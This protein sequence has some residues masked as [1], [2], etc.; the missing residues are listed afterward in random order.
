MDTIDRRTRFDQDVVEVDPASFFTGRLS[1]LIERHGHLA[2]AGFDELRARPLTVEVDGFRRTL[3]GERGT[4]TVVEGGV[5][6]AAV[7][8][9]AQ[10][11]F[12]DWAQQLR[13]FSAMTSVGELRRSSGS[14]RQ[15]AVWDALWI[16][17]LE[18]WPVVDHD[19]SFVDRLGSPL[20]LAR[21]FTPEDD[22]D[23]VAHFL[24]EAGFLHLRGWLDPAQ[25]AQVAE[26]MDGAIGQYSDGDDR[27]W[28]ATLGDGTRQCVRMQHF[29]EHSPTTA[30]FLDSDRWDHL[31][32]TI[33]GPDRLVQAPVEGNCIEALVKPLG[34]TAGV[35]DIPW[36]RDCNFGRHAYGCSSTTVGVSVTP[37]GETTGLLR[38]VAGSH[39]FAMP[40]VSAYKHS[41]LPI[42]ALPTEAGDV[43]VH[44]SCT[45][46]EAM[47]PLTAER[48]VMYTG[49]GLA[50]RPGDG[51]DRRGTH[52]ELRERAARTSTQ[53]P[54]PLAT[55]S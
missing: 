35:S 22:P 46:H 28:W 38:V 49:F 18:G 23:D 11:Q 27:S 43:T 31:R 45:L 54:S 2:A 21:C 20:D 53:P 7:V 13:T 44:L 9:L 4:I 16:A 40:P 50:P 19:L 14:D 12:S 41:Y 24:R 10:E 34:V 5:D 48:K 47:P 15:M 1:D 33:A 39:R 3:A 8:E 52:S 29:L 26:D 6:G 25:M 51:Q 32:A 55:G 36:H 37:G 42:V 17:L 30:A